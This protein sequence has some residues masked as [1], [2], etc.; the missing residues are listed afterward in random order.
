M[1]RTSAL[2]LPGCPPLRALTTDVLGLVKVVEAR[3][4]SGIPKV[5]DTWGAPDASRCVLAASFA[6][7]EARPLLAV[8]RK[9]SLVEILNPLNGHSLATIKVGESS[10]S[11]VALEEDPVVGLHL[12][13]TKGMELS[14]RL[15]VLLTC[16]TKGKASLRSIGIDDTSES[17]LIDSPSTW[18]VCA[19][20]KVICSAVDTDEK[21]ALFGGKG[22]EINVWDID[23]CSKTWT[24]KPPRSN[25]LGIFSPTW[26]TAATF[27]NK[28]DHRKIVAGTNNNQIRLYDISAQRKPVIS[29]TF[30]ESPIKAV[31]EGLD[32]YTVYAGT[33]SGD[34]ASFDMR[35]G[36][37]LGCFIGK[38]CGSIRSIVK[39]PELP[40]LASCGLDSYLRLW[41]TRTRQLLSAVFLKQHLN[42]VVIDSH[43]SA[44]DS[45]DKFASQANNLQVTQHAAVED[46]VELLP[47]RSKKPKKK[48]LKKTKKKELKKIKKKSSRNEVEED[49]QANE[50]SHALGLCEDE[51]T[52]ELPGLKRRKSL[53]EGKERDPSRKLEKKIKIRASNERIEVNLDPKFLRLKDI[54]VMI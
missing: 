19:A 38:C 6:D 13:K 41:D 35:T 9:N 28:E 1:P 31:A 44:E 54:K 27:L 7:D 23:K 49:D 18:D 34:L 26:F 8:A 4:K 30:R 51:N 20:G 47:E 42:N 50:N 40:V 45:T 2:E 52:D 37:L 53:S 12:L 43:F 15:S 16:T 39:H 21:Y 25:S 17:T 36:K 29:V 10:S 32:G 22:I 5:V 11:G 48:E 33:G 14:T 24:A 3:G 46:D